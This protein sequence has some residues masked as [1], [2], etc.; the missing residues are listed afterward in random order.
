MMCLALPSHSPTH[1]ILITRPRRGWRG[2]SAEDEMVFTTLPHPHAPLSTMVGG[3]EMG[4]FGYEASWSE[5]HET[6]R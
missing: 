2:S 4:R 1:P 5:S 3:G 6:I